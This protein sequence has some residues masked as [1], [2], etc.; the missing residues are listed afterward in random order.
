MGWEF[1]DL[2][3]KE[4]SAIRA[5]RLPASPPTTGRSPFLFFRNGGRER[6]A[7]TLGF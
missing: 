1:R 7:V 4:A 6:G 3:G 5:Q 2:G